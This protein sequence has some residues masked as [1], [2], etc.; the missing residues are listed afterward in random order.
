MAVGDDDDYGSDWDGPPPDK[1]LPSWPV[2]ASHIELPADNED[3][4]LIFDPMDSTIYGID[5]NEGSRRV[6]HELVQRNF[7]C[8]GFG[9]VT[10]IRNLFTDS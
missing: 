3:I 4:L 2:G 10:Q 8:S 1:Q 9:L 7:W 5:S 6:R